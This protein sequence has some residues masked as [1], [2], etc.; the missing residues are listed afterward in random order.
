ME[1]SLPPEIM[2]I[3]KKPVG[4]VPKEAN[5]EENF[6]CGSPPLVFPELPKKP[7][8]K[9]FDANYNS[10]FKSV[11]QS[12]PK[13]SRKEQEERVRKSKQSRVILNPSHQKRTLHAHIK[14]QA[15]EVAV[16]NSALTE[17]LMYN[18]NISQQEALL[19]THPVEGALEREPSILD[20]SRSEINV[21]SLQHNSDLSSKNT[22]N[23]KLASKTSIKQGTTKLKQPSN[24][25]PIEAVH[26][27]NDQPGLLSTNDPTFRPAPLTLDK[28]LKEKQLVVKEASMPE[29]PVWKN[30]AQSDGR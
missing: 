23:S 21:N 6:R 30:Y 2:G 27:R 1:A 9:S 17:R 20:T 4:D 24:R 26:I 15:Y 14:K 25:E 19:S 29:E 10:K 16:V 8:L 28:L 18:L 12:S 11:F 7:K 22:T 13:Q 3:L 5:K